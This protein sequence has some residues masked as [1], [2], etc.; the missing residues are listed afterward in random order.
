MAQERKE[1]KRAEEKG[2]LLR[3]QEG[4]RRKAGTFWKLWGRTTDLIWNLTG[5]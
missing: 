1:R 3:I 4:C 2:P 5:S